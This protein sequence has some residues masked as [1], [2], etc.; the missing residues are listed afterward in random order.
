LHATKLTNFV[1]IKSKPDT[2]GQTTNIWVK[3][4]EKGKKK[5][6]GC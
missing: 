2:W 4:A 6:A 3:P 1:N 5:A